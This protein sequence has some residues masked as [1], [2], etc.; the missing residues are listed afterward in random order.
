MQ[1]FSLIMRCIAV[2]ASS[3]GAVQSQWDSKTWYISPRQLNRNVSIIRLADSLKTWARTWWAKLA[4][5]ISMSHARCHTWRS[6]LWACACS[7]ALSAVIRGDRGFGPVL[8]LLVRQHW[9]RSY[10]EISINKWIWIELNG[11]HHFQM[12]YTH[13]SP[14]VRFSGRTEEI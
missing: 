4:L 13:T 6:R 5:L 11:M 12:L 2:I 9:V 8:V 1:W 3:T 14:G 10:V 7:P